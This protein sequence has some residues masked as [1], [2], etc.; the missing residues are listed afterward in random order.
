MG[1]YVIVDVDVEVDSALNILEG[2]KVA[3]EV[4]V[5]VMKQLPRV[6]EVNVSLS[7]PIPSTTD[8]K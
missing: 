8:S 1:P 4:R 7:S 6:G 3:R 2:Q 5:Q